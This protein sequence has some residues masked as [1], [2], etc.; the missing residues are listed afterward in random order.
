M[1]V[2]ARVYGCTCMYVCTC[3]RS[4]RDMSW[5]V[6]GHVL[7][8]TGTCPRQCWNMSFMY[9]PIFLDMS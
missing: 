7:D 6:L 4:T 2:Y 9:V 8:S 5:S 1:H 3:K